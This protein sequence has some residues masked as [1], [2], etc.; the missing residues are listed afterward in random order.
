[1]R[2]KSDSNISLIHGLELQGRALTSVLADTDNVTFLVGTQSL[3]H[4][5]MIYRI[6]L[7]EDNNQLM[8]RQ[9]KHSL[10]EIWHLDSCPSDAN[11]FIS[12]FGERQGPAGWRKSA[13]IMKLPEFDCAEDDQMEVETVTSLNME[14]VM[15]VSAGPQSPE[16]SSMMWHP[17]ES[18]RMV[19]LLGDKAVLVDVGEADTKQVWSAVHS[20]R[21][22]T[23]VETGRWNPHRNYHQFATVCGSQ[24]VAW[25][26]RTSDQCWT[27]HNSVSSQSIRTVD[28]NPN[29]QYYMVTGCDDG[30]V[31]V[32]DTRNSGEV[33]LSSRQHSHWVWS[34]RYNSYHDQLVLSSGSDSRVVM[35]SLA[36]VSSEPYGAMLEENEENQT[37][38]AQLEDGVISVWTDHEDSVYTA[39]WSSADPWTFASLSYDGRLV[40]GQV[41]QS[42]KF[43]I[44]SML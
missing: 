42:V 30:C 44:L 6:V 43:N 16:I 28:F 21:G 27:L 31:S 23:K 7:D 19:C 22:Q 17:N 41:P 32:W 9:Y 33:L 20:V 29:K 39:E 13:A 34:T 14:T 5:N 3:R 2:M 1:M 18:S 38:R 26:T 4:T 10:G 12:T 25:D 36:S 8:K 11:K 40:I 15:G 37:K 24:V 35:S